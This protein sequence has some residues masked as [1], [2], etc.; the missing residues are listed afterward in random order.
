M[1]LYR[2]ELVQQATNGNGVASVY[3]YVPVEIDY[4]VA[5][6]YARQED[7]GYLAAK[8]HEDLVVL[9]KFDVMALVDVAYVG[10]DSTP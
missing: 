2:R 3:R 6:A 7:N 9:D 4:E 10:E 8:K 1:S 5:W